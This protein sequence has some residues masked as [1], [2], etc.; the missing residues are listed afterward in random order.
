LYANGRYDEARDSL[1]IV[2]KM[3]KSKTM[4]SKFIFD[5]E[6]EKILEESMFDESM[7]TVENSFCRGINDDIVLKGHISEL[8]TIWQ[9][10]RNFFS[11]TVL[12]TTSAFCFF[13]INF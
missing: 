3:N 8:I 9:I 5:T 10:R 12:L 2:A 1:K 7:M 13:L 4:P 11:V 6:A